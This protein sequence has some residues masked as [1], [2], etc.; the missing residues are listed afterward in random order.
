MPHDSHVRRAAELARFQADDP[1]G[2]PFW[3]GELSR[4]VPQPPMRPLLPEGVAPELE[5]L[6]YQ[7]VWAADCAEYTD[8]N[9][10][11]RQY[12]KAA[13]HVELAARALLGPDGLERWPAVLVRDLAAA[14]ALNLSEFVPAMG[15]FPPHPEV[16]A[17]FVWDI[18]HEN[19]VGDPDELGRRKLTS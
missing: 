14:A 11:A 13:G 7:L 15:M 19:P 4:G 2:G 9:L 17:D 8:A 1:L 5:A 16:A 6:L 10:N 12:L 18:H 3:D